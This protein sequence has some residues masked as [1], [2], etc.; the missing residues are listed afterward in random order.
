MLLYHPGAVFFKTMRQTV[1][2]PF[3]LSC[4]ANTS[5]SVVTEG[6]IT[7]GD[8]HRWKTDS[9]SATGNP[10]WESQPS[11]HV[12]SDELRKT[13]PNRGNICPLKCFSYFRYAF[14][15][16]QH[17]PHG[18]PDS[19]LCC[20][21]LISSTRN[22]GNVVK[23]TGKCWKLKFKYRTERINWD[24]LATYWKYSVVTQCLW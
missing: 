3:H 16:T 9:F 21:R 20:F 4:E 7:V 8:G 1:D 2:A 19:S 23:T 11:S 10:D 18:P 17:S 12:Q 22:E 24:I 6:V 15:D 13:F 5:W 14:C